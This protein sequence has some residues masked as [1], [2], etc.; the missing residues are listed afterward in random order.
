[1]VL[2]AA[3]PLSVYCATDGKPSDIAQFP[4]QF[5]QFCAAKEQQARKLADQL[6]LKV[7]PQIWDYFKSAKQGD[8][9]AV[10]N[11]YVRLKRRANQYEGSRDD[12]AVRTPVWQT[13]I[14]VQTAYE[15][16]ALGEL[17]YTPAADEL[18][19]LRGTDYDAVAISA[20]NKIVPER[21]AGELLA[22]A[23]DSHL[24]RLRSR[25]GGV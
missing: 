3:I 20:L 11:A 12:P 21:L 24:D 7:S 23:K 18:F 6:D 13:I 5:L 15:A 8:W 2:V 9:T 4:P 25:F 14:E 17:K 22:S 19:K 1:M 10:S 16:F